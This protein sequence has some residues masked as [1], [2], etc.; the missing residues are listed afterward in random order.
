MIYIKNKIILI[1]KN[2]NA[3]SFRKVYKINTS[4]LYYNYIM[5]L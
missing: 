5:F 1:K 2:L 3:N 4:F